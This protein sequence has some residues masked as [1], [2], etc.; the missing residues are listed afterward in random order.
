MFKNRQTKFEKVY[1]IGT[2][3]SQISNG[4]KPNVDIGDLENPIDIAKKE[5]DEKKIPFILVRNYPK[6]EEEL[7][8]F[9]S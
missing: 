9:E 6:R 2:R 1:I 8:I 3:A 5:Y 4:A 7:Y